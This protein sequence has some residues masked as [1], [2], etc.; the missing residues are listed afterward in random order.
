M[1][2]IISKNGK[3]AKKLNKTSFKNEEYLQKYIHDNPESIPL[4]DIKE[5]IKVLIVAKEFNTNS[6]PLDVLGIDMDGEI[7]II[8]TKLYKNPDKRQVVAQVLDYGAAMW[9]EYSNPDEFINKINHGI[10]STDGTNLNQ[11]IKDFYSTIEDADT[12][13]IENIKN[14]LSEGIFKFIILMDTL[15]D[16]LKDLILFMN[17]NTKFDIYVVEMEFYKNNEWEIMIP[18]LFGTDIKKDLSTKG[19]KG[20][21]WDEKSFFEAVNN[22]IEDKAIK[23]IIKNL[24][25]FTVKKSLNQ[26]FCTITKTGTFNFIVK[27]EKEYSIFNVN[28]E[29]W[30]CFFL[31]NELIE[32]RDSLNGIGFDI[33]NDCYEKTFKVDIFNG[34]VLID[35]FINV[36][37][38]FIK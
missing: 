28:T 9:K 2:I 36:V 22:K 27:K 32:L 3:N 23:D 13:I 6:G 4:Y 35:D 1:A 26:P 37:E 19:N 5:D 11:K 34:K 14:N 21:M 38:N 20:R 24:Y 15:S 16:R 30:M 8:E 18:K 25:D 29:G 31:M 7:Y 33:P 12:N 10:N 17:Q